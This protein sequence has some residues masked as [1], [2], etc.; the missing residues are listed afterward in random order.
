MGRH[1][2]YLD[3][4]LEEWFL[5][6]FRSVPEG[7]RELAARYEGLILHARREF[8]ERFTKEELMAVID[9]LNGLLAWGEAPLYAR[10]NVFLAAEI[11]D[12]VKLGLDKKWNVDARALSAKI[13]ASG[14]LCAMWL[15]DLAEQVWR[16]GKAVEEVVEA[17]R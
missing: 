9:S 7:V 16:G 10:L 2:V 15:L 11:E 12:A 3:K 4:G 14:P 1:T 8:C 6:R 5:R 17:V 13:E